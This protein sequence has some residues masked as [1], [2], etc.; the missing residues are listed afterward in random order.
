M[1]DPASVVLEGNDVDAVNLDPFDLSLKLQHRAIIA[2]PLV[3]VSEVRA[4]HHLVCARQVLEHDVAP[5]LRRV[6]DWA[7]EDGVG[8]QQ[9][10]QRTMVV[11]LH[12][13]VAPVVEG[14]HPD[15][16]WVCTIHHV[17]SPEK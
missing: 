5:S 3:D 12:D 4:A 10:P 13:V 17:I 9:V 15:I 14:G 8:M 2:A 1:C 16:S 6:Y 11:R 7:L